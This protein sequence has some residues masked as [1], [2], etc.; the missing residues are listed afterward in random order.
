M[1]DNGATS[2]LDDAI[3]GT[4]GNLD[5]LEMKLIAEQT[6]L[7]GRLN[8]VEGALEPRLDLFEVCVVLVPHVRVTV[9]KDAGSHTS[10]GGRA[11]SPRPRAIQP[12]VWKRR[13]MRLT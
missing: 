12:L 9:S 6:D 7:S 2:D 10:P 5:D 3:A 13:R 11:S 4:L 8:K 1:T